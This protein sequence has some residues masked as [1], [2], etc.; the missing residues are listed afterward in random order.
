MPVYCVSAV[1]RALMSLCEVWGGGG[2]NTTN[3]V[4]TEAVVFLSEEYASLLSVK[5]PIRSYT[6]THQNAVIEYFY[7]ESF[8]CMPVMT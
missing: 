3:A 4:K 1:T 7:S 5:C 2:L 6:S 8:S